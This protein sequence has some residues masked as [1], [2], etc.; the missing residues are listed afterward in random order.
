VWH[1]VCCLEISQLK[2]HNHF[3]VHLWLLLSHTSQSPW[4]N[5]PNNI[6]W[7]IQTKWWCVLHYHHIKLCSTVVKKQTD[8]TLP[9]MP[10]I[11]YL[12]GVWHLGWVSYQQSRIWVRRQ[13]TTWRM[14]PQS[15]H[16]RCREEGG[17]MAR[18]AEHHLACLA[19]LS[20]QHRP[21]P[22]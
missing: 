10:R 1:V 14:S 13:W 4:L 16:L 11:T 21:A 7:R 12:D 15:E 6:R 22:L 9:T 8:H 3:V 2:H 18:I 17:I 19:M 20:G 5:I